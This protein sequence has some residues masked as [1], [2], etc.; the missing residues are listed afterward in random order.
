MARFF[1]EHPVAAT[2]LSVI[3]VVLGLVALP[4][5][6]IAQYPEITPPTVEVSATYPGANARDVAT[7][8]AVPLEQQIN[9]VEDM[10]YMES[11][12]TN[13]G[14]MAL[15]ITFE[16]GTD[17]NMAQVLVQNRV[18]QA[19][20]KLPAA[21]QQTGVTTKKK[22]PSIILCVNLVSPDGRYDQLYLSNYAA[23]QVKDDLVGLP[24]V[25]DVTFLG[26]REYSMRVWLYPDR[27][28]HRDLAAGDIV[29]AIQQQNTQVAAG[30]VGQPPV[31]AG[32]GL[33]FQYPINTRGRL[34]TEAEFG[35]IIV[36][37][38]QDGSITRLRDV[39]RVELG[40]K[41]VD[42][43]STLDGQ[44]TIT[45][46]VFQLPGSNAIR[47][48]DNVR[49]KM[50]ELKPR[51]PPGL[52]Y[53]IVYDTT[54]FIS[55]SVHEVF[56]AL[57]DAVILVAIVVLLFLQDWKAM[58]LPMIDVPVSLIGTLAVMAVLGFTLNNLTLFGLVLAIGIVV[59]D[60]IVVLESVEHWMAQGLGAKAATIKAMGEITGPIIAIT[61]VL[62]AV[63][64]PGAFIAGITGQF[65]RQFA[66]T[67][68]AAMMISAL[69]AMTMTPSRAVMILKGQHAGAHGPGAKEAL[70]WWG[71]AI[72]CGLLTVWVGEKLLAGRLGLPSPHS[73]EAAGWWGWLVRAVLFLPGA[74]LGV[75][76][77]QSLNRALGRVFRAFNRLFDRV[78]AAYGRGV[79]RTLRLT[80]AVM[81]VYGGLLGLTYVGFTR[82]PAGFIPQQDKGYLIVGIQ[83]PDAAALGRTEKVVREVNRMILGD[84]ERGGKYRGP[85]PAGGQLY[86]SVPGVA[87]TVAVEGMSLLTN[88]NGSNLG[89]MFIV[90]E[91][92]EERSDGLHA[93]KILAEVRR[94]LAVVQEAQV[95][96]F[97]APPVDGL[98]T[99]GGFKMQVRD[100]GSAGLTTLQLSAEALARAGNTAPG[101]VGVNTTFRAN[102]P[103]LSAKVDE[104]KAMSMHVPVG[105]INEALQVYLGSLYVNDVTL[106]DRNFQVNVQADPHARLRA[107]DLRQLKV[108]STNGQMV[109]LGTMLDVT[110]V[111]GPATVFRYNTKPAA[112]ITGST[113][114]GVSSGQAITE[115]RAAAANELPRALDF[116]W[117]ELTLL[118][119][120]AGNT[121]MFAF[122][123]AVLLV[124]LILAFQYESWTLPLAV[125]LVVPMCL[126]CSIVGVALTGGDINI[127]TQIGFVVLVGLASK[128]AILIVEYAKVKQEEGVPAREAAVEACRLRLRPIVMT[129]F[130]F[131]LGVVP[132]MIAHGAGAEMRQ[133]LG[134]AVF[135][136]M[137]GVTLFGIF[138]TP[139]FYCVIDWFGARGRART[140]AAPESA[141]PDG[142]HAGSV[143][144]DPA[145]HQSS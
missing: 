23:L 96:V 47:T 13:D 91:P 79:A 27:V 60:A 25:G 39:G 132:L 120:K 1:I 45:L 108:R 62:S 74:V 102:S 55:E 134:I 38:G 49:N 135:S 18:S 51:F 104:A 37:T 129:S 144:K 119:I 110:E 4:Q 54:P 42:V 40:A 88:A 128:N 21:V 65:F 123:L 101:L 34:K 22:S 126:L 46:A 145:V 103:Q 56:N 82:V 48:A 57:R 105:N 93:N 61:L 10:L 81:L 17:L 100:V 143:S 50:E 31:P 44:P 20:S 140:G 125:I 127:F 8:V 12:C 109:P 137:L 94:R 43:G 73:H 69:N 99:A 9:G 95:V 139:V 112:A 30:Q 122:G 133:T 6:P 16:V 97:G 118:Q 26:E 32:V 41:N 78:T 141:L 71:V 52:E 87:H 138:L 130:A 3:V 70:P 111:S 98:G 117:T 28:A 64:I 90:L 76:V 86:Q 7:Q 85:R 115:M 84:E 116:Q 36:K 59:D 63:L 80:V 107:D 5:L 58:I 2:V 77:A 124:F 75:L 68:A 67:I 24:G 14:R 19:L 106:F 83:L 11:K 72:L 15:T 89:S 33:A 131:I 113:V 35:K 66:L 92:F 121:A 114:P 29:K 136:G 53:R 142:I